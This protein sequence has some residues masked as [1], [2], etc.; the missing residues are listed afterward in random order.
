M[1]TPC[2]RVRATDDA[3]NEHTGMPGD[4]SGSPANE[5]TGSFFFWPPVPTARKRIRV[6]VS[7]LWEAA[8]LRLRSN[9]T[10]HED[11]LWMSCA[12]ES[13]PL[14]ACLS[15]QLG[16][17]SKLSHRGCFEAVIRMAVGLRAPSTGAPVIPAGPDTGRQKAS[18]QMRCW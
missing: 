17:P 10:G 4:W 11:R 6:T 3:G 18:R 13:E 7:T 2:F 8:C 15:H 16:L 5:G 9:D 1:I 12:D 14:P